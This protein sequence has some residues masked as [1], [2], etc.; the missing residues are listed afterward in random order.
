MGEYP[1]RDQGIGIYFFVPAPAH[2]VGKPYGQC[3]YDLSAQ[4]DDEPCDIDPR[5]RLPVA[6][7]WFRAQY[8]EEKEKREDKVPV[9]E[10]EISEA[11]HLA[12]L[13]QPFRKSCTI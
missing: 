11:D 8:H 10:K 3:P 4:G 6:Q 12:T 13:R 2:D 7:E 1:V 5:I 9:L